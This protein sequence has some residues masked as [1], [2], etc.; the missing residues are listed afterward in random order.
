M[1]TFETYL[2][3]RYG[4]N[5]FMMMYSNGN[6]FRVTCLLCGEFTSQR[7]IPAQRPA[8]RSFDVFFDLRL[9]TPLG[10]QSLGWWVETPPRSFWRHSNI[11]AMSMCQRGASLSAVVKVQQIDTPRQW[12]GLL[13]LAM[14]MILSLSVVYVYVNRSWSFLNMH[15]SKHP[16]ADVGMRLLLSWVPKQK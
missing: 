15:V 16:E 7:W 8:K 2:C 6:I 4:W 10:K 9:N 11:I 14:I 3:T 5:I 12:C 13:V 1:F